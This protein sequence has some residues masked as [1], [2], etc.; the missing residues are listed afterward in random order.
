MPA[1]IPPIEDLIRHRGP[2]L[3]IDG[4]VEAS[5]THAVAEVLVSERS[6]F[7]RAGS[8]VPAYVGLEYMAQTV[9][10]YDGALRAVSGEPPAIGFLLGTRRYAA[11]LNY[12]PAGKLLSIRV[13]MVF[14]ENGMASFDC[15]IGIGGETC[16]TATLSV[17]R[18]EDGGAA[19]MAGEAQ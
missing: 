11:T 4:L 12:F 19:M 3:L 6:R 16:V 5:G 14:S 9:A 1:P 17:Y 18:P 2:M 8:G 13:E 10:A 7:Y 15:R